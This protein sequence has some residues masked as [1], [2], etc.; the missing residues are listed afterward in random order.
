MSLV[1]VPEGVPFDPEHTP[2]QETRLARK[3]VKVIWI[4]Q[5]YSDHTGPHSTFSRLEV[6]ALSMAERLY[7]ERSDCVG[8]R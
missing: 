2:L 4:G 8:A 5:Y 1:V 6:E 7:A 3:G